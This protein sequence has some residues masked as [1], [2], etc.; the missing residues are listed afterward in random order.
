MFLE[1]ARGSWAERLLEGTQGCPEGVGGCWG[2]GALA[3]PQLHF[4]TRICYSTSHQCK[5]TWLSLNHKVLF[6]PHTYFLFFWENLQFSHD[7]P[8]C[9]THL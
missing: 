8:F 1:A 4:L 6:T 5:T 3:V 9:Y 2:S 7:F